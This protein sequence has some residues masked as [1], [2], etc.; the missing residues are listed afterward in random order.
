[1]TAPMPPVRRALVQWGLPD[2]L[3]AWV[4]GLILALV[5]A[6]PLVPRSGAPK[7]EEIPALLGALFA[8]SAG[9]VGY[10]ALV[11]A[12]RK[13]LGSLRTDFGLWFDRRGT[14]LFA[15][16]GGIVLAVA[17]NVLIL[18]IADL[19]HLEKSSQE[20]VRQ[21]ERATGAQ[22]VIFVIGVL[23]AAP[24][25]EELLFRGALL[26]ALMRKTTPEIAVMGSAMVF[27]LAHVIG[28]PGTGYYVPAFFG[29]GIVSG[30]LALRTGRIG[31]SILLHAGFNLLAT[32]NV[33]T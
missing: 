5:V 26:R 15:L 12:R 3:L 21:F 8:Q 33:V 17:L 4:S 18:P 2:V 20:V 31:P 7:R 9:I 16:V 30:W 32:L 27:A 13:G 22:L 25:A 11:A 28:D 14:D 19:A 23:V 24:I 1:M 29:L 10:L 6:A